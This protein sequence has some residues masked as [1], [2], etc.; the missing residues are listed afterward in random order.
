MYTLIKEGGLVG[1]VILLLLL[2]M[3]NNR[4][5][6]RKLRKLLKAEVTQ[7]DRTPKLDAAVDA[8]RASLA[9]E[10]EALAI[11]SAPDPV[12]LEREA[13]HSEIASMVE[14]QP[15]EVAQLLRGW[16]ADRRG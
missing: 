16:L 2:A 8:A 5:R 15:E 14:Q 10:E 6:N 7:F 9:M 3:L 4:R 11:T 1:A 13:R 12:A